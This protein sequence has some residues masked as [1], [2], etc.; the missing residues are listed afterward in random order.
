MDSWEHYNPVKIVAKQNARSELATHLS[1]CLSTC[2]SIDFSTS[3]LPQGSFLLVTSAGMVRRKTAASLMA[4]VPHAWHVYE[5]SPE[6]DLDTLDAAI[7]ELRKKENNNHKISA[8]IA[9]G[10][11][12]AIDCAKAFACGLTSQHLEF[13]LHTWLREKSETPLS[14]L[15]LIVLPTTSGTGAEVTHFATIWDNKYK[16]KYSLLTRACFAKVALLDPELTRSLPWTE[17]LYGALDAFSHALE[18]LWNKN[19]TPMS[20]AFAQKAITLVLENLPLLEQNLQNIEARF[21]LQEAACIAGLAISQSF[22][23]IGHSIS[24]PLTLHYKVPHGLSCSAFLL[25]ILNLVEKHNAWRIPLEEK[26]IVSLRHF[27]QVYAPHKMV[28]EFC[29]E[30]QVKSL[31]HEMFTVERA[32]TFVLDLETD[33][34]VNILENGFL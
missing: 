18:T 10:G 21:K 4:Q 7:I 22:S 15:P 13:P 31:V 20:L 27:L 2:L 1:I 34:V 17:T 11:G 16:K 12:S 25:P 28:R 30:E 26:F 33:D 14:S 32:G 6:P 24:Y 8:V 9:L 3:I 29:N 19:A 23:S 5:V